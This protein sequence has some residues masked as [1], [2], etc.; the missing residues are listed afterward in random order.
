MAKSDLI[1]E[2]EVLDAI[3]CD[4]AIYSERRCRK[5]RT[6]QVAFSPELNASRMRIKAWLLL[7]TK[8]KKNKISSRL[9]KRTPRKANIAMEIRGL[10][11]EHLQNHLKEEYKEYYKIK[12]KAMQLRAIALEQLAETLAEQ[13]KSDKERM[14]KGC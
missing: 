13:G 9:I 10:S 1:Q 6:G 7:I 3:R 11:E 2:Y 12:G 8:A 4:A 14:L 5:L